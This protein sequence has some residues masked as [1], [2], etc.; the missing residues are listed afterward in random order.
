MLSY[1]QGAAKEG[2]HWRSRVIVP[3]KTH[4]AVLH[5]EARRIGN[6]LAVTTGTTA[7]NLLIIGP[8]FAYYQRG[9]PGQTKYQCGYIGKI[10]LSVSDQ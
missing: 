4:Y 8:A 7:P 9:G 6:T 3:S 10:E 5:T 2:G 1:H